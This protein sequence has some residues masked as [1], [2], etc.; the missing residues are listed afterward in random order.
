MALVSRRADAR[1]AWSAGWAVIPDD[2]GV[3]RSGV[4]T[5]T[6]DGSAGGVIGGSAW[7]EPLKQ[8]MK[9]NAS[10]SVLRILLRFFRSLLPTRQQDDEPI[11]RSVCFYGCVG[12][13]LVE[14]LANQRV[15]PLC[16]SIK[17]A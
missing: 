7:A 13:G 2:W 6:V 11:N 15:R 14:P 4:I 16:E 1:R 8:A 17:F 3:E 10:K 9:A 12:S 5:G